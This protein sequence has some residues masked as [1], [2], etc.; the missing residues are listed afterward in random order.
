MTIQQALNEIVEQIKKNSEFEDLRNN[1]IKSILVDLHHSG[2]M[3]GI[4]KLAAR[5]EKV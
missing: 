5:V 2:V 4:D 3:E 1:A